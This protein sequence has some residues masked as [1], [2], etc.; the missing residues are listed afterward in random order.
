MLKITKLVNSTSVERLVKLWAQR[1]V[2]DL[3]TLSSVEGSFTI[4]ELVAVASTE[5]RTKTVAE[6]LHLIQIQ[7]ERAGMKTNALFSYV[8]NV[9]NLAEARRL[10]QFGAKVYQKAMEVYLQQ[11]PS[12]TALAAMQRAVTPNSSEGTINLSSNAFSHWAKKAI[13]L[14]AIEQLYAAL[15]PSLVELQE[16]H[17]ISKDPRTIGFINT[18]FHFTAKLILQKLTLP[19][20]VLVSPYLKFVEEQACIPWTRLCAAAAKHEPG[21]PTLTVVEQ[22]LPLSH[23][24]AKTVYSQCIKLFPHHQSRRGGLSDL[25]VTASTIRDLNMFQS[26]LWLCVLEENMGLIKNEL[27][28][29]CVMVFPS[30]DVAWELV[31]DMTKLLMNEVLAHVEP[32]FKP[33]VLPYTQA[34]EQL[35]SNLE[36]KAAELSAGFKKFVADSMESHALGVE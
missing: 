24:I 36:M 3:S 34:M 8:P 10:A 11:S 14:P 33:L 23:E 5:G 4:S 9:V 12:I 17:L 32:D 15:E 31:R 18:Q 19:E 27:I 1:Y 7:C 35:F 20:Q 21:S 28:P 2:P 25:G 13:E 6:V 29:L 16:Q 22:M 26:Y 30:V